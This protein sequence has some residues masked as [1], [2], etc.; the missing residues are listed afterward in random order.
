MLPVSGRGFAINGHFPSFVRRFAQSHCAAYRP[1]DARRLEGAHHK[2]HNKGAAGEKNPRP[3]AMQ[4]VTSPYS[5]IAALNHLVREVGCVMPVPTTTAQAPASMA[6]LP[7]AG[8]WTW[9]SQMIG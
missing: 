3:Q 6:V 1:A 5:S 4:T 9:P 7:S 8:V 2:A